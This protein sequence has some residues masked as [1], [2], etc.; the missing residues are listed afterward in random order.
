[1]RASPGRRGGAGS[2][3]WPTR[4]ATRA[5]YAA[6]A[7]AVFGYT[8]FGLEYAFP[9]PEHL[10]LLGAIVPE[11]PRRHPASGRYRDE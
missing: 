3:A 8:I 1:M 2:R 7:V 5:K 6:A 11:E 4:P 10:H 9:V